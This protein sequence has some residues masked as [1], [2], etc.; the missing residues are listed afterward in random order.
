MNRKGW[1]GRFP[2]GSDRRQADDA[3][4]RSC[5]RRSSP[6]PST[7]Q[8]EVALLLDKYDFLA[9]PVVDEEDHLLGIVTVDDVLDVITEETTEASSR[10]PPSMGWRILP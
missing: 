2:A 8:E 3:C 4:M 1:W 6:F 9:L 5:G 10:W 7:D